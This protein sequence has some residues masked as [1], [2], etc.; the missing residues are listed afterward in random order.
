[1]FNT[2]SISGA[3]NVRDTQVFCKRV[4]IQIKRGHA[5]DEKCEVYFWSI[6]DSSLLPEFTFVLI[7]DYELN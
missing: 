1:M 6:T 5:L 7:K 3:N 2:C 4:I